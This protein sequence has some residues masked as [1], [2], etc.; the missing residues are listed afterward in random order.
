MASTFYWSLPI[1]ASFVEYMTQAGWKIQTCETEADVA[2][3]RDCEPGDIVVSADSDM[4]AYPSISTL[5]RPIARNL[6]LVYNLKDAR[7]TLDFSEAQLTALAVVSGNDYGKSIYSLGAA[8]NY[9]VIKAIRDKG[10][11]YWCV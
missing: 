5:W 2:I 6:I 8:T 4:M 1:R 7:R 10:I 9:S 3:A 11:L